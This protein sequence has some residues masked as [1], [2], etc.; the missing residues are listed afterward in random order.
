MGFLGRIE[1]LDSS[2]AIAAY[3]NHIIFSIFY[4]QFIP[5]NLSVLKV[6][7][8]DIPSLFI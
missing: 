6:N 2:A 8:P 1:Y 4:I 7:A 3:I 5:I